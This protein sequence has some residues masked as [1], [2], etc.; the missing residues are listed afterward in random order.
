M[1]LFVCNSTHILSFFLIWLSWYHL[2][3][4]LMHKWKPLKLLR[5]HKLNFFIF[6]I[7]V[8]HVSSIDIYAR[9]IDTLWENEIIVYMN[10]CSTHLKLNKMSEIFDFDRILKTEC[11]LLNF[12]RNCRIKNLWKS[13]VRHIFVESR[14]FKCEEER[15]DHMLHCEQVFGNFLRGGK[16]CGVLMKCCKFKGEQ[17]ITLQML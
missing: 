6:I 8:P 11:N 5:M 10:I 13:W 2:I 7:R 1:F 12:T 15:N 3:A 16:C 17:A 9:A 4:H 14:T